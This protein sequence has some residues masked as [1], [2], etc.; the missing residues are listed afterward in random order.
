MLPAWYLWILNAGR[1]RDPDPKQT[2]TL[3]KVKKEVSFKW[4]FSLNWYRCRFIWTSELFRTVNHSWSVAGVWTIRTP[5]VRRNRPACSVSQN[6]TRGSTVQSSCSRKLEQK[7]P[8]SR[9]SAA[10]FASFKFSPK[11]FPLDSAPYQT[12]GLISHFLCCTAHPLIDKRAFY[13]L[14]MSFISG[15]H[16]LQRATRGFGIHKHTIDKPRILWDGH[17]EGLALSMMVRSSIQ[18]FRALTILRPVA[19]AFVQGAASSILHE[20]KCVLFKVRSAI[21]KTRWVAEGPSGTILSTQTHHASGPRVTFEK[22]VLNGIF[23]HRRNDQISWQWFIFHQN[24]DSKPEA[25][26]LQRP[27]SSRRCRGRSPALNPPF[28][29]TLVAGDKRVNFPKQSPLSLTGLW[30]EQ[31][32]KI[33]FHNWRDKFWNHAGSHW[34]GCSKLWTCESFKQQHPGL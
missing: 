19:D 14:G 23:K 4:S 32:A 1:N 29:E 13:L 2:F 10:T 21:V 22:N 17:S 16:C 28:A 8:E 7:L 6:H 9:G 27:P 34:K 12:K 30:P 33:C 3:W 24:P 15:A 5:R 11:T 20:L 26:R 18:I 25:A 31:C